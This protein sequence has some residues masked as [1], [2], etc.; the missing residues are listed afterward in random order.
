MASVRKRANGT[1]QIRVYDGY[2][3]SG[4]QI[5]R[6]MTWRPEP[7]WSAA[8]T[9]KEL[10]RQKLAFEQEVESGDYSGQHIKFEVF[11]ER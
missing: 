3:A 2:D 4:H 8:R 10:E 5:E 9:K 6:T 1:Y 11:V 7:G